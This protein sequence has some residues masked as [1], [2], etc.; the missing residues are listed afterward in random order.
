MSHESQ[1][2][3]QTLSIH[4]TG[5]FKEWDKRSLETKKVME[6][7]LVKILDKSRDEAERIK[8]TEKWK[9]DKKCQTAWGPGK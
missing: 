7:A 5:Y 8:Y 1:N 3:T 4:K 9:I 2:P 6:E